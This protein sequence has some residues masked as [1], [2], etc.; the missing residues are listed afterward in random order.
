MVESFGE[1]VRRLRDVHDGMSLRKL[2]KLAAIDPG[3]LSR[4]ENTRRPPSRQIAAAIDHALGADGALLNLAGCATTDPPPLGAD[5]WG[6]PDAEA[7]AAAL[8]T[9]R[10]SADNALRLTHEWLVTDPPQVYEMHAGR[11]IGPA[12]VEQ[13]EQRVHQL[14]LLD[15]HVGGLDTYQLV[16]GELNTTLTLLRQA[17]Y[18]EPVGRRLLAVIGELCQLAGYVAAD[19]GRQ[20][21]AT[22]LYLAGLR[23]AHASGDLAGAANNVS[24]LAYLFA[25][26]ANPREGALMAA[27]AHCGARSEATATTRAMLL[28]R[29]AWT[30][31]CAGEPAAVDRALGRVEE[32]Y[33]ARQPADDP[34][35]VY[36]LT[37]DEIAIMAGRCWTQLHRPLRAVPI[38]ENAT[39]GYGEDTAR[40]SALY[41]TWLA[42]AYL[43]ANEVEQAAEVAMRAL[44][45]ARH[46]RSERTVARLVELRA[47]FAPY[48]GVPVADTLE[49]AW[50][51]PAQPAS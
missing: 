5:G 15:D 24:S 12:T 27:S 38:L 40:E 41:L 18:T 34:I 37:E 1:A 2:A 31:A 3:H 49:E 43:Q 25:N 44:E 8:L 14:R 35:W 30:Q 22:R 10:P 20:R 51:P 17:A 29:V 46:A 11:R 48:R 7:L 6:R 39:R 32:A 19:A 50:N 9:E 26:T 33:S 47:L 36:W 28:E 13:V 16:T 23:A 42:E 45:L 21:E 4:I